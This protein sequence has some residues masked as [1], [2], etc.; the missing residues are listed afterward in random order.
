MSLPEA[1]GLLSAAGGGALVKGASDELGRIGKQAFQSMAGQYDESGQLVNEGLAQELRGMLEFQ[2]YSITTATGS[3]FGM[4]QD[5]VTGEMTYQMGLS[6]REQELQQTL[7]DQ[8][9]MFFGLAGSPTADR[10]QQVYERMMAATAPERERQRL[11]LEERLANQGRLGVRTSMFGGTPEQLAMA[12]AEEEAR[13]MA[14]LNAM[15]FAGQEQQ[16][17]AQLGSGMLASS[18]MPQAQLLQGLEPGMSASEARRQALSEQA[19]TYGQ[20]YATGLEALLQSALGQATLA[21]TTGQGLLTGGL[22]GLFK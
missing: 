12:K 21:G 6:P 14:I 4:T 18:Y 13:N 1:L 7:A 8:A 10:E 2:P 15:E 17:Q 3:Q 22:A 20:T 11:A 5:P 9:G 16:R 19:K